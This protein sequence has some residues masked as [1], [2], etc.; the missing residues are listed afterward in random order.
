MVSR[1]GYIVVA[2][3]Q[4][5]ATPRLLQSEASYTHIELRAVRSEEGA[6]LEFSFAGPTTVAGLQALRHKNPRRTA[7]SASF[8]CGEAQ[9]GDAL[10][11]IRA[12]PW[13][14]LLCQATRG[15]VRYNIR[16]CSSAQPARRQQP[17][18]YFVFHHRSSCLRQN[19]ISQSAG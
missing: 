4:L 8:R 18:L 10:V 15:I 16:R 7:I 1:S 17:P 13:V 5:N 3:T 19:T 6:H 2:Q 14:A 9:P 11:G 12:S